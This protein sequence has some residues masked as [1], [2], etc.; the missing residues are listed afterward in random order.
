VPGL[1]ALIRTSR[2]SDHIERITAEYD[3]VFGFPSLLILTCTPNIADCGRQYNAR[4]LR[5]V[6]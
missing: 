5:P 2:D 1:F 3:D 6:T 4:N